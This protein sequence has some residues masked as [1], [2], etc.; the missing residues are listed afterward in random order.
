MP[1]F[2]SIGFHFLTILQTFIA[3]CM[4]GS[5]L[6]QLMSLTTFEGIASS[7][8]KRS[9]SLLAR[10]IIVF[11]LRYIFRLFFALFP[12]S[13]RNCAL[14]QEPAVQLVLRMP[15]PLSIFGSQP[16]AK[17]RFIF[18]FRSS[19]LDRPAVERRLLWA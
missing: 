13:S 2:L 11:I 14:S 9:R 8:N 15:G 4:I 19:E 17:S 16:N 5:L 6:L 12:L 10:R 18:A 7:V 1:F 3:S